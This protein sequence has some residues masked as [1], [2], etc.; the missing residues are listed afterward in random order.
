[1]L[2]L[3]VLALIVM[4]RAASADA[5]I[6][7][8]CREP[9]TF[10]KAALQNARTVSVLEWYFYGRPE[11]GWQT[12]A[13][14]I[15]RDLQTSCSPASPAFA[16]RLSQWQK[17]RR[18]P[19]TGIIDMRSLHQFAAEWQKPRKMRRG[20]GKGYKGCAYGLA[21]PVVELDPAHDGTSKYIMIVNKIDPAAYAAYKKMIAAAATD[22]P[23]IVPHGQML[24]IFSAHRPP[25]YNQQLCALDG[26]CDGV[27]RA[28]CTLHFTGRALD[29]VV[30]GK[31][32]DTTPENRQL[33]S[34]G[35]V[36]HWLL[37]NA[38]RFGFVNYAYEPWHWE[39]VG[40]LQ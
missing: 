21:R 20:F 7:D 40:D 25:A 29:L 37:Q 22:V 26:R 14:M 38:G 15:Q 19:T 4:A 32:G 28:K 39:Y 30:G 31:N 9:G 35:Q 34:T 5:G 2:K 16:R 10:S 17:K 36:Y 11:T 1:M 27:Q 3:H 8:T 18:L 33:Q 6:A 24:R 13:P 23:D 12:V